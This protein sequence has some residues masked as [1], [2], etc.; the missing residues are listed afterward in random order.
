MP[1]CQLL[2]TGILPGQRSHHMV[3]AD[4]G[5]AC[6]WVRNSTVSATDNGH[7]ESISVAPSFF[8]N[9]SASHSRIG[10]CV[11]YLEAKRERLLL[12]EDKS[13]VRV[14]LGLKL[15]I[16]WNGLPV[17]PPLSLCTALLSHSCSSISCQ[18][19]VN[20]LHS[21]RVFNCVVA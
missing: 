5:T 7:S 3:P 21:Y 17:H 6:C 14:S 19:P 1:P 13:L 8:G 16:T 12:Y 9:R 18:F 4:S 10:Q 2:G 15:L 20:K 11:S